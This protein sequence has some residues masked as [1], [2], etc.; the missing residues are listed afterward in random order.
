MGKTKKKELLKSAFIFL[1]SPVVIKKNNLTN[2]DVKAV[3][4]N[5]NRKISAISLVA[6]VAMVILL[7]FLI[8]FLNALENQGSDPLMSDISFAGQITTITLAGISIVC[9]IIGLF[10]RPDKPTFNRIA[11][12][13]LY[14]GLAIDFILS[15]WS[16]A[17]M[18]LVSTGE[19]ISPSVAV[20]F[21]MLMICQ[22]YTIDFAVEESIFFAMFL[23][24][25]IDASTNYHI[26]S[27]HYYYLILG[28]YPF[29]KYFVKSFIFYAEVQSYCQKMLN[30][31]LYNNAFYDELTK[32]K[33]RFALREYLDINIKRWRKEPI[34]LLIIIFDIDDFKHYNDNFSHSAGDFCLKNVADAI[35]TEFN[36]PNL[37]F[38][39]YGGE[40]FL[41]FFELDN[42]RESFEIIEKVR[43]AVSDLKIATPK[44]SRNEII[45]ISV[46]GR[47]LRTTPNFDFNNEMRYADNNLY[48]AKNAGKNISCLNGKFPPFTE[49]Q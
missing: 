4:D 15:F 20:I 9:S 2:T 1:L 40:E 10:I 34:N 44:G 8:I 26:A 14:G 31:R 35:R 27:V 23:F 36:S 46:G 19:G 22:A 7:A 25:T 21:M 6:S 3:R 43:T 12:N 45:T 30:D 18:G 33:N 11:I 39:R 16:D 28:L 41:L 48:K 29:F 5:A 49:E 17:K 24:T 37:D 47:V 38:F 42:I 32:C 13:L